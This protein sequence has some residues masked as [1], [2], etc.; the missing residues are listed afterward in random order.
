MELMRTKIRSFIVDT[1]LFGDGG[2]LEDAAS[3]QELGIVDS[4]GILELIDFLE[5]EVGLEIKEDELLPENFDSIELVLAFIERKRDIR[6]TQTAA[7]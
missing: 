6:Q 7:G 5:R 2:G 1:F 4:T 3:F